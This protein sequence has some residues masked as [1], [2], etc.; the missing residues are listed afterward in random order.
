MPL[1]PAAGLVEAEGGPRAVHPEE[2]RGVDLVAGLPGAV[3][4]GGDLHDLREARRREREVDTV[5]MRLK[6]RL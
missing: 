6:T 5:R 3:H 1:L 2:V 4:V